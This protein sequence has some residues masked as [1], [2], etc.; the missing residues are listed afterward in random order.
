MILF[1]FNALLSFLVAFLVIVISS[2]IIRLIQR[3]L[4]V[5]VRA[6]IESFCLE[7]SE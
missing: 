2:R 4:Y 5:E 7:D 3:K 6:E 1:L